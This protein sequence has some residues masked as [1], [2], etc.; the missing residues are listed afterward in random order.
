PDRLFGVLGNECLKLALCPL[1]V[2]KGAASATEQR[3]KLRPGI[4]RTHV[5][6]ADRLGTRSW[7]LGIDEVG[8]F[9][10]LDAAPEL[11]LSRYQDAQVERVHRDRD[12][13]PLAAAGDD[14]QHRRAEMS[15]PH[16]VLDLGHVLLGRGL[17]GERPGQ[18]EF[19]LEYCSCILH[20]AIECGR[21]PGDGRMLVLRS[22][23]RRLSSSVAA[24]SCTTRLPDRSSGSASPRF[25]CQ[26]WIKAASSLP[27][28]ILAS[29]PPMKVP[30]SEGVAVTTRIVPSD[31]GVPPIIH[32]SI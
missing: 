31:I 4:R 27:I 23:P 1:M 18:H 22:Y 19:G 21:H 11:L 3:C 20:N 6:D 13:D 28:I 30:R 24:P 16:I 12:L 17:L 7:G 5:D 25:S 32:R 9:A 2:Q 29:E 26:S 8:S 10:G 14:G 15:D